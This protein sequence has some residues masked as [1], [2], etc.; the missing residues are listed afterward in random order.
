MTRHSRISRIALPLLGAVAIAT[1]S[2]TLAAD[3]ADAASALAATAPPPDAVARGKYIVST[4]ACHDCHTPFKLGPGGPEPDMSR[5]LSGHPQDLVM[6]PA[7]ALAL[8]WGMAAAATNT[9]WAGPWGVSFT[10][11]LT[12]DPETGIGKWSA[13]NF[14]DTIRSGRHL[15]RGR[16][17]LP[18]MPWPVYRNL[19]DADLDAVFA[20]LQTVPPIRNQVPKPLPPATAAAA[21]Q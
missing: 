11:N 2:W 18:P 20:Y 16:A 1:T 19:T 10:A 14:R 3:A 8:P 21:A 5:A 15:G 7:P 13:R 9:A 17:I 6:P 12:P 4:A